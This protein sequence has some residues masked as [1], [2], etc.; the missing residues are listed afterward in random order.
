MT[1][2]EDPPKDRVF[3]IVIGYTGK[4]VK[5]CNGSS[6]SQSERAACRVIN[7][8][9]GK[10][11]LRKNRVKEK[12]EYER[13]RSRGNHTNIEILREEQEENRIVWEI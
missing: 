6:V 12:A 10:N 8:N 1:T 3:A 2:P 4:G 13:F 5:I 11:S 9:T 7:H